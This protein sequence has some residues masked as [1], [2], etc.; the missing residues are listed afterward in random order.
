[1]APP[2][3]IAPRRLRRARTTQAAVV[4][5][6]DMVQPVPA[7]LPLAVWPKPKGQ[8]HLETIE[9]AV[10]IHPGGSQTW[11]RS[12]VGTATL[13]IDWSYIGYMA[14][15]ALHNVRKHS[16]RGPLTVKHLR[17][18]QSLG[19]GNLHGQE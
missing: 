7:S 8:P 11:L 3:T 4:S 12:F 16:R 17:V 6:P 14:N 10:S 5:A 18:L 9:I 1:M 19:E 2:L 13:V 15:L